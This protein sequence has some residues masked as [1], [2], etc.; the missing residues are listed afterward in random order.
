MGPKIFISSTFY[1]LKYVREDLAHFVE[2]YR[3]EPIMFERGDIGYAPGEPL[4]YA[5]YHDISHSDMVILVVGGEYGSPA[6]GEIKDDD[7]KFREYLSVT[8]KEFSAAMQAGIPVYVFIVSD[9]YAEFQVYKE[10]K[11]DIEQKKKDVKFFAT[12][13][14]NVFRFISAIK[15]YSNVV[16]NGFQRTSDIKNYMANQWAKYVSLYLE[17]KRK[18]KDDVKVIQKL[19]NISSTVERLDLMVDEMGKKILG[20]IEG[21]KAYDLVKSDQAVTEMKNIIVSNISFIPMYEDD[22][23]HKE[24][25]ETLVD[26]IAEMMQDGSFFLSATE[27]PNNLAEFDEKFSF[28]NAIITMVNPETAYRLTE[29]EELLSRDSILSELKELLVEDKSFGLLNEYNK[30]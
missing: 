26:K 18:K 1:D 9:V 11:D 23:E 2:G 20:H 15:D 22:N 14:I 12:K 6:T 16:I 30:K 27:D 25:I 7:D 17:S 4:D 5:C 10:N 13:D 3:Y 24:F 28:E 29:Y 8:R 21:A 19:V